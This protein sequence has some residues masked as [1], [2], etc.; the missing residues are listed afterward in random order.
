MLTRE[1]NSLVSFTTHS[2]NTLASPGNCSKQTK[3][4]QSPS[5]CAAPARPV[6]P[7]AAAAVW[8]AQRCRA[9]HRPAP[10]R[11]A[12]G[13]AGNQRPGHKQR[14]KRAHR[15]KPRCTTQGAHAQP[16]VPYGLQ[17]QAGRQQRLRSCNVSVVRNPQP[18]RAPSARFIPA[19]ALLLPTASTDLHKRFK[20]PPNTT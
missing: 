9:P 2:F 18:P 13:S 16:S 11:R 20:R 14:Y 4:S 5:L 6:R 15:I 12:R 19:A 3:Q 10:T 8:A 1:A 7:E 17:R